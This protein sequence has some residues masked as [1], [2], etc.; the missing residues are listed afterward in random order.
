[1][2]QVELRSNEPAPP[3]IAAGSDQFWPPH[4]KGQATVGPGLRNEAQRGDNIAAAGFFYQGKV[5]GLNGGM[6]PTQQ[7]P[8]PVPYPFIRR[9]GPGVAVHRGVKGSELQVRGSRTAQDQSVSQGTRQVAL[10][11]ISN[12]GQGPPW[13]RHVA[14]LS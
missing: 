11:G 10:H 5:A 12:Q 7:V 2:N 9:L 6:R 3:V 4:S 8:H 14:W 13:R 1:M